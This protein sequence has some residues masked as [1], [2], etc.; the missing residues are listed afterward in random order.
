MVGGAGYLQGLREGFVG[1]RQVPGDP[2]REAQVGGREAAL[3]QILI[4]QQREGPPGVLDRPRRVPP[5]PRAPGPDGRSV[6]Q[7]EPAVLLRGGLRYL[8]RLSQQRLDVV[9]TA[10]EREGHGVPGEQ[11]G[12][13]VL[14]FR[15]QRLQPAEHGRELAAAQGGR[16]AL[17]DQA[18][19]PL[20]VGGGERVAYRL[21]VNP[22]SSYQAEARRCSSPASP[23]LSRSRRPRRKSA[24]R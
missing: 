12:P 11:P 23:G 24:K 2:E 8:L 1:G 16:D 3:V 15:R 21:G 4:G 22:L 5:Q 20:V 9:G 19:R 7:Q 6:P 17:L 13:E 14:R 18:R 10:G